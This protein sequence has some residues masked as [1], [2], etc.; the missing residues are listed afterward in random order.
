MTPTTKT[1]TLTE[2]DMKTNLESYMEG[3]TIGCLV[4]FLA[5]AGIT[6]MIYAFLFS[7]ATN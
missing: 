3:F 1:V 6:I 7:L 2:N 5:G 4:G